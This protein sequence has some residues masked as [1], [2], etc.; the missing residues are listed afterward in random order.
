MRLDD[1]ARLY[2]YWPAGLSFDPEGS[3]VSLEVDNL[4]TYDMTWLGVVSGSGSAWTQTA[5]TDVMFCGSAV[6][7]T[8]TDVALTPGRHLIQPIA[9]TP[10]GQ[11]VP[12]PVTVLDVR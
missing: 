6:T 7:P 1:D 10:D 8:G 5:R 9:I 11:R 4:T 12:G 2:L 3:P